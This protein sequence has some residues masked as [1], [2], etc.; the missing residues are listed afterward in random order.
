MDIEENLGYVFFDKS[1]LERAFT[2]KAHALEQRQ[3]QI[4]CDDQEIFRTLG[5]AVLKTVLIDL[6]IR[7]GYCRTRD[8]LTQVKKQLEREEN[9]ARVGESLQI[10][11]YLRLGKGEEKHL[12]G[13]EPYVL[14]ETVEALIGAVFMDGGYEAA[15][16]CVKRW[17][18]AYLP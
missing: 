10:G 6:L 2:R 9:L 5:D 1:T 7:G 8:E 18:G 16:Q 17:F 15:Q 4:P 11:E 14:A 12:A 3:K 13:K